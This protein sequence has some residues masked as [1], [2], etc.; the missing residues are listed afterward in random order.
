MTDETTYNDGDRVAIASNGIGTVRIHRMTAFT[1]KIVSDGALGTVV[2]HRLPDGWILVRLD[3][4]DPEP[5]HPDTD[6]Y[7]YAPVHPRMVRP[8]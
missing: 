5:G 8:A 6:G 2:S 1:H 7:L 3:E 4:P